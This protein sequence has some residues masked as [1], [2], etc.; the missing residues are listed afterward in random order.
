MSPS[1]LRLPPAPPS[2]KLEIVRE[3]QTLVRSGIFLTYVHGKKRTVYQQLDGEIILADECKCT[4][5]DL[6]L[7]RS[8]PRVS[9]VVVRQPDCPIDEH[10][11][12]L[13]AQ[14]QDSA[15]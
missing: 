1:A 6:E 11:R 10:K 2:V 8:S 15:W 4:I 7:P 12:Q 5:E 9:F 3:R 14:Q 13:I